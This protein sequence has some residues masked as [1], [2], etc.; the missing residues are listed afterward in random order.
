MQLYG[1]ELYGTILHHENDGKRRPKSAACLY[2][3]V[4][5]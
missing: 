4:R 5:E 2:E 3:I 1:V